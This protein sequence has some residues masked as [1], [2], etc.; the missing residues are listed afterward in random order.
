MNLVN[1][2]KTVKVEFV[3]IT[4]SLACNEQLNV[5]VMSI[6]SKYSFLIKI[7]PF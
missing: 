7:Y 1:E 2:K 5:L 3:L 6:S 4:L